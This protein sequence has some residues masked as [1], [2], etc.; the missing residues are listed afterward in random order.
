MKSKQIFP[1]KTSCLRISMQNYI[2]GLTSYVTVIKFDYVLQIISFTNSFL[3]GQFS[4]WLRINQ[5]VI[6]VLRQKWA[7]F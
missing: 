7:T 5:T 3:V 6:Q 1:F 4:D 2:A